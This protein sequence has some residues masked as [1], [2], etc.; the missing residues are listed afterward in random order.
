MK[1]LPFFSPLF[2]ALLLA[3]PSLVSCASPE[4]P[5][6]AAA[7]SGPKDSGNDSSTDAPS[8]VPTVCTPGDLDKRACGKCGKQI[9]TCDAAGQW[10]AWKACEDEI[11]DAEC[12]I[13]ETKSD[14]C[15]RCGTIKSTCDPVSCTFN[16]GACTGSGE[17]EPGDVVKSSASCTTPGE[18]RI[19]TCSDKCSFGPFGA[20][21]LPKGWVNAASPPSTFPGRALG[22]AVWT[23]KTMLVWGGYVAPA[24]SITTKGDGASY[25]LAGDTWTMLKSAPPAML[26]GRYRHTAVWDGTKRMMVWGGSEGPS[27][28]RNTGATY[29]VTT[30]DWT[31]ISTTGAPSARMGHGAVWSTTTNEMIVWGGCATS[32]GS[33]TGSCS[34]V[35]SDGFL[36]DPALDRWAAMPPA[37]PGFSGRWL[38]SMHWT[39]TEVI[40]WGGQGSGFGSTLKNGP[41]FDPLT[42]VWTTFSDPSIA[43]R[44]EHAS[45]WSGKELIVW[46]GADSSGFGLDDGARYLPGGS[47][48]TFATDSSALSSAKRFAPNTWYGL[49]KLWVWSGYTGTG[50]KGGSAAAGGASYDPTLEKWAEMSSDGAPSS[51]GRASVVWTGREMILFGG[52]TVPNEFGGTFP[53]DTFLYRP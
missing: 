51:R 17:C 18:I 28:T 42:R 29:D 21:G 34:S 43:G 30:G 49:G 1:H 14:A 40:I 33:L 25:D 46:G 12:S 53:S 27:S 44:A 52:A 5:F 47:W 22:T 11:A 8:D 32:P 35:L 26:G 24:F 10:N 37:P 38:H 23:G 6:P 39:G 13:G 20:C 48:T 4:D 45:V 2:R 15:E 50:G 36:Y 31:P 16:A 3:S 7:D 9:R 41:R 19:K